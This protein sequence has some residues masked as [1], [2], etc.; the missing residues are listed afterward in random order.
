MH[1]RDKAP[2]TKRNLGWWVVFRS[3][4]GE[5]TETCRSDED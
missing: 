4:A 3:V 2:H 1:T 5:D